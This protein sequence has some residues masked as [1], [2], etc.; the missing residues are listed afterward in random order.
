VGAGDDAAEAAV[1]GA[2][3]GVMNEV[4]EE[5]GGLFS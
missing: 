5:R 1:E 4:E 2:V 3:V